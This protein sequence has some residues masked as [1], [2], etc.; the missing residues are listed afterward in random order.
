MAGV[1]SVSVNGLQP[2]QNYTVQVYIRRTVN[3]VVTHSKPTPIAITTKANPVGGYN[4]KVTNGGTDVQLLGGTIYAGTFDDGL[5]QFNPMD[6]S[7]DPVKPANASGTTNGVALNQFGVAAYASGE[8]T[9]YINSTNGNA[10]F[11][12][13]LSIGSIQDAGGATTDQLGNYRSKYTKIIGG[14]IA[15]GIIHSTNFNT[16]NED[17]WTDNTNTYLDP[18]KLSNL[19]TGSAFDLDNGIILTPTFYINGTE[20]DLHTS[21]T[22]NRIEINTSKSTNQILFYSDVA[23]GINSLPGFIE[24]TTTNY[25]YPNTATITISSPIFDHV[26]NE[27]SHA[28]INLLSYSSSQHG[29]IQFQ[30]NISLLPDYSVTSTSSPEAV[31]LRGISA[32]NSLNYGSTPSGGNPGDIM[33][34]Y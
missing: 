5:G 10:Y 31:G 25:S 13:T 1:G 27:K 17:I 2:N 28:Q 11:G 8:P 3:G 23:T 34:I 9:F 19:T 18:T 6:G 12:G 30:G 14:D 32:Q 24:T 29:D 16:A 15:T 4:F 21:D 26:N 20:F 33:L 7:T 22:G